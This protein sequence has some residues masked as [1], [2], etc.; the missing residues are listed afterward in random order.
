MLKTNPAIIEQARTIHRTVRM[1]QERVV[2]SHTARARAGA[3][4]ALCSDLT[5]P[6]FNVLYAIR[7]LGKITMKDLAETLQVS[8][9]SV[10]SMVD[11]LEDMGMVLREHGVADRRE[12]L[13]SIS[14]SGARS[15]ALLEEQILSEIVSLLQ[16]VGPEDARIWA[17]IY[18][19]IGEILG[20]E[21]DVTMA[22]A[23]A[24]EKDAQ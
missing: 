15:L 2:R 10:S 23:A 9:P 7:E 19:R 8:A 1:I 21:S 3:S 20:A 6:Q 11:R 22:P 18:G 17:R 24:L 16:Q 12:V 4:D 13:V 5:L 14:E